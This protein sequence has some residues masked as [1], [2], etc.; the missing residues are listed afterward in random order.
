MTTETVL[1]FDRTNRIGLD[2][3]IFCAGK[4]VDADWGHP[5]I[6]ERTR[7]PACC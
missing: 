4:S 3:A 2:E 6:G 1:D 7:V 5:R